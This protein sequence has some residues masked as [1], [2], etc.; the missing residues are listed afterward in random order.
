MASATRSVTTL[1]CRAGRARSLPAAAHRRGVAGFTLLELLVTLGVVGLLFALVIP[2]IA[3]SLTL[4]RRSFCTSNLRVLQTAYIMYLGDHE[5][6]F[7]RYMEVKPGSGTLYYWGLDPGGGAEGTRQLDMSQARLAPY[8][9]NGG[10]V[11]ICPAMPYKAAYFK[12]KYQIA[13]YGYG[14]NIY[15]LPDLSKYW[16]GGV[17]TWSAIRKPSE[18]IIWADAA[19]IN[20]MQAPAS[21]S[22]PMIE[23]WYYLTTTEDSPKFHFR[24]DM[25]ANAVFGDLSVRTLA[26]AELDK[27]C[28]GRIGK[29]EPGKQDYYLRTVK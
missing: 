8:L 14:I 12:R 26:A 27:R 19:Q 28:D 4:G 2:A 29:I 15:L 13:S 22:N 5:G 18:T 3:H 11:E 20:T 7:F 21:A 25:K 9:G 16:N 23:E 10:G 24:H 1:F 17:T 6:R